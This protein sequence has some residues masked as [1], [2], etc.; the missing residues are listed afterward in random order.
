MGLSLKVKVSDRINDQQP[1]F[2]Q[3]DHPG[4]IAFLKEYY[5]FMEKVDGPHKII[6]E[7]VDNIDVDNT[8][9]EFLQ[10]LKNEVFSSA[11]KNA[12]SSV[13]DAELIKNLRDLYLTKG[14]E[15][16]FNFILQKLFSNS[17]ELDY[18]KKYVFRS[19][20]NSYQGAYEMVITNFNNTDDLSNYSGLY[21]SQQESFAT[22]IIDSIVL[23]EPSAVKTTIT[24]NVITGSNTINNVSSVAN[25]K[26]GD[27]VGNTLIFP[28]LTRVV[29]ITGLDITVSGVSN[30]T[31]TA[32]SVTFK[33]PYYKCILDKNSINN[34]FFT[35]KAVIKD[36]NNELTLNTVSVVSTIVGVD[37]TTTGSLYPA[38]VAISTVDGGGSDLIL[39]VDKLTSGGITEAA[40]M[41]GGTGYSVGDKFDVVS[42]DGYGTG[43]A[44]EVSGI[45][46]YGAVLQPVIKVVS[47]VIPSPP[48]IGYT[49]TNTI[50]LDVKDSFG[51][52]PEFVVTGVAGG[53]VGSKYWLPKLNAVGS[54]YPT[55][56]KIQ[57]I[58]AG[59]EVGTV[60]HIINPSGSIS[61]GTNIANTTWV[62]PVVN[63]NGSGCTGSISV[64]AAKIITSFTVTTVGFNY[65]NPIVRYWQNIGR[66]I[67]LTGSEPRVVYTQNVT[68]GITAIVKSGAGDYFDVPLGTYYFDV[69]EQYGSGANI[70]QFNYTYLTQ[71]TPVYAGKW[72]SGELRSSNIKATT[73]GSGVPFTTSVVYDLASVDI[74]KPGRNYTAPTMILVGGNDTPPVV[75]LTTSTEDA[76]FK[77]KVVNGGRLYTDAAVLITGDGVGATATATFVGGVITGV[78]VVLGGNKYKNAQAFITSTTGMGAILA[79]ELIEK[80]GIKTTTIV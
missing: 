32:A 27:I 39:K 34:T 6:R 38:D 46:G 74:V 1:E 8:T 51:I 75:N 50:V 20:D 65:I 67:P 15:T 60:T 31:K 40:V 68:G 35:Y 61:L 18:G 2:I 13:S 24:G 47:M 64:S 58:D 59:L 17:A 77:I 72:V 80:G 49:L 55:N 21:I 5:R 41:K 33:I 53:T 26:V 19:S 78:T 22:A 42:V 44:V 54:G 70:T 62:A 28:K 37:L 10:L 52:N 11:I 30:Q 79:V 57:I 66:T 48:P 3:H 56:T 43:A 23:I 9:D 76:V 29:S 36:Q 63:I 14:T 45:D 71:V 73:S 12:S 4:I 25:I 69:V 7:T 16:S